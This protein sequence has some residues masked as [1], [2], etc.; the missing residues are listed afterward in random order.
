M[1]DLGYK[2]TNLKILRITT[3]TTKQSES[4]L[5]GKDTP[6]RFSANS[7]KADKLHGHDCFPEHQATVEAPLVFGSTLKGKE[8]LLRDKFFPICVDPDKKGD[9]NIFQRVT[10]LGGAASLL[11]S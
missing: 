10:F 1:W 4:Y 5:R 8:L 7:T 9:K 6:G 3:T 11:N 2:W